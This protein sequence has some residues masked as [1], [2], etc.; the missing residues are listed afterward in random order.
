MVCELSLTSVSGHYHEKI[1]QITDQFRKKT[2][3]QTFR[4]SFCLNF[5]ADLIMKETFSVTYLSV[6]CSRLHIQYRRE[7]SS[8]DYEYVHQKGKRCSHQTL[9]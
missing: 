2:A 3:S 8:R 7:F 5:N 1:S 9:Q 4:S 6:Y